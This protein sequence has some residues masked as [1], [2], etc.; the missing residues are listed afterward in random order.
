MAVQPRDGDLRK[1]PNGKLEIY[2]D[3][4]GAWRDVEPAYDTADNA[5]AD[6]ETT[7]DRP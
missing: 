5:R 1:S 2:T 3:P 7:D 6:E 4:P